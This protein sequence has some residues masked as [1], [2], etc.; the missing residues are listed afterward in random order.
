M[1]PSRDRHL[2]DAV[3]RYNVG[4]EIKQY[5]PYA[6]EL[7]KR[8]RAAQKVRAITGEM[9][10]GITAARARHDMDYPRASDRLYT[11]NIMQSSACDESQAHNGAW[12]PVS[13]RNDFFTDSQLYSYLHLPLASLRH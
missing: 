11:L 2:Y 4:V 12:G 1:G 8:A 10:K 7:Q 6:A 9:N 13:A 3:D 5:W